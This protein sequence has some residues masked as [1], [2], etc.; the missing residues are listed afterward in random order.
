MNS[1]TISFNTL[2]ELKTFLDDKT[3]TKIKIKKEGDRRGQNVKQLHQKAKQY[4]IEHPD[5]KYKECLKI[6][7]IKD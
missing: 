4:Q 6:A 3:T 1:L 2:D 7:N 5:I